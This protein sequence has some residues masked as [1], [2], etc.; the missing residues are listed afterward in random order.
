VSAIDK[1]REAARKAAAALQDAETNA[2][3]EQEARDRRNAERRAAFWGG[4]G[5]DLAR[6]QSGR[7]Q[8]AVAVFRDAVAKGDGAAVLSAYLAYAAVHAEANAFV[9]IARP[10]TGTMRED[11]AMDYAVPAFTARLETFPALL[12]SDVKDL[13]PGR[14]QGYVDQHLAPMRDSLEADE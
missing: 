3:R 8:D 9:Q 14:G 5:L 1:A 13:A 2:A 11:G 6:A 4:E 7:A 12:E 10:A